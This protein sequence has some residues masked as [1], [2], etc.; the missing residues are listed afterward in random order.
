MTADTTVR[1]WRVA[2]HVPSDVLPHSYALDIGLLSPDGRLAFTGGDQGGQLWDVAT[3]ARLHGPIG[4]GEP[5]RV[6]AFV[7]EGRGLMTAGG[8]EGLV[9]VWDTESSKETGDRG[10]LAR[11]VMAVAASGKGNRFLTATRDG[12]VQFWDERIAPVGEA[13]QHGGRITTAA[14]S[15]DGRIAVTCGAVGTAR[16]WDAT[17]GAFTGRELSHGA[18]ITAVG[19]T[20][21]G[22]ML[23]TGGGDGIVRTWD[24][25]DGRE[26]AAPVRHDA[27]ITALTVSLN[28]RVAASASIDR[29]ARLWDV[30]TGQSVSPALAHSD[31]VTAVAISPDGQCVTTGSSDRTARVWDVATGFPVGPTLRHAGG[32]RAVRYSPNGR[33]LLTASLDR[34]ARLWRLPPPVME[35]PESLNRTVQ[36]ITGLDLVGGQTPRVLEASEWHDL[37]NATKESP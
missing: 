37:R 4:D 21:D 27:R 28:G 6:A 20:P 16:L 36:L 33:T 2:G 17:A 32:V 14:I 11:G 26:R 5:V 9:R 23:L 13:S 12:T 35:S 10:R 30:H 34:T 31:L 7:R 15:P 18:P 22:G 25:A 8:R 24:V 19:F 3:G 29:T 1:L